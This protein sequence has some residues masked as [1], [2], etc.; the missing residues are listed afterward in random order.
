MIAV[1]FGGGVP[2]VLR[3][4]EQ[5]YHLVRECFVNGVMDGEGIEGGWEWE[6]GDF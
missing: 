6:G 3:P 4:M 2:F 1:L 5:Y